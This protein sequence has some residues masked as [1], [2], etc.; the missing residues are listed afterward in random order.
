MRV[1]EGLAI[2]P[3]LALGVVLGLAPRFVLDVIEPASRTVL[4]LLAR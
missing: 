3:L 2:V 1:H 4:D